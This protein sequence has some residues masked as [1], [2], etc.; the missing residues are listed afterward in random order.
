M[1]RKNFA[2]DLLP[3][4]FTGKAR[5]LSGGSQPADS[6]EP[7]VKTNLLM[8]MNFARSAKA[9]PGSCREV[10][11]MPRQGNTRP[12]QPIK[13]KFSVKTTP[14]M[15]IQYSRIFSKSKSGDYHG[16]E[17]ENFQSPK[18]ISLIR[19]IHGGVRFLRATGCWAGSERLCRGRGGFVKTNS[20]LRYF[21]LCGLSHFHTVQIIGGDFEGEGVQIRQNA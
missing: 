7:E 1:M 6:R 17:A 20:Q 2:G 11:P 3:L 9:A 13:F 14:H 18:T 16:N 12:F 19:H 8:R 21:I 5:C 10:F 15:R 4:I